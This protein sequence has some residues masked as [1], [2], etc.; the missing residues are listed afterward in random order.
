M[1]NKVLHFFVYELIYMLFRNNNLVWKLQL[2]HLGL[3]VELSI[4]SRNVYCCCCYY[5]DSFYK[6]FF[7]FAC[8]FFFFCKPRGVF[9]INGQCF[10][11]NKIRKYIQ[12]SFFR[13][14]TS[15]LTLVFTKALSQSNINC[16]SDKINICILVVPE[17]TKTRW[18][19]MNFQVKFCKTDLV[20]RIRM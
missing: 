8:L 1:S 9:I 5:F 19:I 16:P 7:S 3:P 11:W 17:I 20:M 13:M 10:M 14:T 18:W 2:H 6:N 12:N 4:S 15:S